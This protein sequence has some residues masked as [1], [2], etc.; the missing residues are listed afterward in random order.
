MYEFCYDYVKVTYDEKAK[1][2]YT[3]TDSFIIHV[4]TNSI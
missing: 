1:P 2:R 4:K 3:D